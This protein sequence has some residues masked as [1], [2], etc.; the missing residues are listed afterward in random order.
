MSTYEEYRDL[1]QEQRTLADTA[2]Q[3]SDFTLAESY[4]TLAQENERKA[5]ELF[6]VR[7]QEARTEQTDAKLV[8]GAGK[9]KSEKEEI[10]QSQ[11]QEKTPPPHQE[12]LIY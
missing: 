7:K 4:D 1:A 5:D 8:K 10:N 12:D 2:R 3:D 11:G 6:S 9:T